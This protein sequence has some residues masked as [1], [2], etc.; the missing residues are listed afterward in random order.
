MKPVNESFTLDFFI[1][2]LLNGDERFW[3]DAFKLDFG[4]ITDCFSK[5]RLVFADALD[6]MRKQ[7][8]FGWQR[9]MRTGADFSQHHVV[10]HER[11]HMSVG[12]DT[13]LQTIVFAVNLS[14]CANFE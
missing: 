8:A 13:D 7:L 12:R 5:R 9:V 2:L 6:G 3:V 11:N 4:A 1:E 10:V 14:A